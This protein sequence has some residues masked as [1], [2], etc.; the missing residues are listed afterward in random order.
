MFH[1][2]QKLFGTF[3]QRQ[4]LI[5][6]GTYFISKVPEGDKSQYGYHL[7]LPKNLNRHEITAMQKKDLFYAQNLRSFRI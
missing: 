3:E 1:V 4:H 6:V 5:L 2:N 7:V